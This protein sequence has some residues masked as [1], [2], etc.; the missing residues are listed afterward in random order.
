[1]GTSLLSFYYFPVYLAAVTPCV[2]TACRKIVDPI[3]FRFESKRTRSDVVARLSAL[4]NSPNDRKFANY[5]IVGKVGAAGVALQHRTRWLKAPL[6]V[7]NGK[8][9]QEDRHVILEGT[10]HFSRGAQCFLIFIFSWVTYVVTPFLM[11]LIV[12]RSPQAFLGV[13]YGLMMAA[14]LVFIVKLKTKNSSED[15]ERIA[16]AINTAFEE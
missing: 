16:T 14:F 5:W 2:M 1:M 8:F 11:A 13:A 12:D 7:F 10:F 3:R 9:K 15:M 4:C 6:T